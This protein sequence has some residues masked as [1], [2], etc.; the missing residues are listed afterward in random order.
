MT[1]QNNTE[2]VEEQPERPS[3]IAAKKIMS[4]LIGMGVGAVAKSVISSHMPTSEYK[5]VR[6]GIL[7]STLATTWAV[8]GVVGDFLTDYSDYRIDLVFVRYE[9]EREALEKAKTEDEKND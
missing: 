6:G 7:L 5:L 8:K 2:I 9:E 3:S 4:G 1:E